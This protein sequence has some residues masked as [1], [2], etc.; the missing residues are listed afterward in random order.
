L[1]PEPVCAPELAFPPETLWP[2][3]APPPLGTCAP[4]VLPLLGGVSVPGVAPLLGV[5]E[6]LPGEA[7]EACPAAA[8][9]CTVVLPP[10]C[11]K[12]YAMAPP[13]ASVAMTFSVMNTIATRSRMVIPLGRYDESPQRA[14]RPRSTGGKSLISNSQL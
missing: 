12:S 6:L 8:A 11:A 14:L 2:A 1:P 3:G 13:R 10:R 5:P 9:G 7:V 4:D